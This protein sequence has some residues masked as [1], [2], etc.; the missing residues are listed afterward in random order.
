MCLT[1]I[2]IQVSRVPHYVRNSFVRINLNKRKI[3]NLYIADQNKGK[4]S[5]NSP[6]FGI[7]L[8]AETNSGVILSAE[9]VSRLKDSNL[10]PTVPEDLGMEVAHKLLEEIYRG[11]CVDSSYQWLAALYMSL[12]AKDVSKFITGT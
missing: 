2:Y 1:F 4:L 9:G 10:G 3:Q 7:H 6:G 12:S 11:G 8:A 5:G